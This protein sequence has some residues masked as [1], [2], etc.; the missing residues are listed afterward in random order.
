MRKQSRTYPE[1]LV[2]AL[3]ALDSQLAAQ[4]ALVVQCAERL[5]QAQAAATNLQAVR[6]EFLR[7]VGLDPQHIWDWGQ[8]PQRGR[9]VPIGHSFQEVM[10]AATAQAAA[11]KA[12][13]A[14]PVAEPVAAE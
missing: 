13:A 4:A 7:Q 1:S 14:R 6:D 3:I 10:A 11:V 2:K 9:Y 12:A 8:A 5:K